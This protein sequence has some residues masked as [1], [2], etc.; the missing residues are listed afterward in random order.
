[1]VK[2]RKNLWIIFG[3]IALIGIVTVLAVL[4]VPRLLP[5]K[6]QTY[7]N[8]W[9]I[10]AGAT[11]PRY[12][13]YVKLYYDQVTFNI[14]EEIH[15]KDG[16]GVAKVTVT[17]PDM[18]EILDEV[19]ESI[20]DEDDL[21]DENLKKFAQDE[22]TDLLS[23]DH[24]KTKTTVEV[25]LQRVDGEWQIVPNEDWNQAITCNMAQILRD[26]FAKVLEEPAE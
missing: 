14:D 10:I 25:E 2:I 18:R 11:E 6:L 19:F 16:T 4:F 13:G 9:E 23:Q 12:T 1:M 7:N 5:H 17:T 20:E 3:I 8:N 22:I 26:Y 24:D 21:S 15:N